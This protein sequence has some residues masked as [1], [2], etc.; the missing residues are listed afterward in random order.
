MENENQFFDQKEFEEWKAE[1]AK[2]SKELKDKEDRESYRELVSEQVEAMMP[3]LQATSETLARRKADV[4]DA[5]KAALD[6]KM[7]LFEKAS[8]NFS[9]TFS[10]KKGDKRIIIG[11]HVQDNYTDTADEGIAMIKECITALATD[12]KSRALVDAV[13]RLLAKNQQ[14]TLKASRI[15]QLQKIAAQ[16][17][18]ERFSLGLKIINEAYQPIESKTYVRAEYKDEKTNAW[19]SVPLGMTEV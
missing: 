16:I 17:D 1:K 2:R 13:L 6:V 11:R 5:F 7:Q 18:D 12:D 3:L 10:N 14:G 4:F 15:L 9:H 8:E 19:V